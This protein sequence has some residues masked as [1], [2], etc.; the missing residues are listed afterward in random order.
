MPAVDGVSFS[1][2]PGETLAVVGES[3][4]G[5]TATALAIL[6][7]LG[8]PGRVAGGSVQLG[9]RSLL[10]LGEGEMT[11]VR[12]VEL[13]MVFQDPMTALNPV[14][15][16]GAQIA[17]AITVHDR[18][19]GQG[20]AGERAVELL[21]L[22]GVGDAPTCGRGFPHQLSGG[23]RQRV[24]L[25]MALANAPKVL[26][27]DEPTTALD[28]TTQ[29]QILEVLAERQRR[30][31]PRHRARTHDLGV[32][33]SAADRVIVMYAGRVVES[34]PATRV[35]GATGPS[36]HSSAPGGRA[37]DRRHP[38]GAPVDQGCA[39]GPLGGTARLSVQP[40][41]RARAAGVPGGRAAPPRDRRR[42]L[43]RLR[44]RR[45]RA[46]PLAGQVSARL[47]FEAVVRT[48]RSKV[49]RVRAV[50]GVS[51]TVE[52][53]TTLALVGESGCGKSTMARLAARLL[54]PD[55]G[56]IRLDDQPAAGSVCGS[57]AGTCRSCSRTLTP[58]SIRG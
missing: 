26:I 54:E 50:D 43:G 39:A 31:G 47:E 38:G 25:A 36:V 20:A 7:L 19:D 22:V 48:F 9:G 56:E 42:S 12:G 53:A 46:G 23:L 1:V 16:V 58:R 41:V 28:A 10:A 44:A 14:Q 52:P 3:G 24:V 51:L 34:G 13:S 11:S 6:G 37:D 18:A 21:E 57:G 15:R 17:E 8:P 55:S 33:A 5:K 2:S 27:A 29:A 32:V 35:L 40:P 45:P 4:S 49:G 30:D